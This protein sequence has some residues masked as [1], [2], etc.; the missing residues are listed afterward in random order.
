MVRQHDTRVILIIFI[1]EMFSF[2]NLDYAA[3]GIM[4]NPLLL[5]QRLLVD[6]IMNWKN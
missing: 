3:V 6:S 4:A 2:S 5:R 1:I